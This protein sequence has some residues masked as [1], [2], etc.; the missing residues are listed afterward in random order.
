MLVAAGCS[1]DV[2]RPAVVKHYYL[3]EVPAETAE[4]PPQF[5]VPIKVSGFEVAPPF[6]D[7]AIVYRMDEQRYE[8]DFYNEFFVAP[9]AMVT[10]RISDWLAARRIFSAALP[11]S[12]TVDA[13]YAIEGLVKSLYVDLRLENQPKAVFALQVFVTRIGNPERRIVLERTYSHE[14][15]LA[16]RNPETLTNG[17]S[18]ALQLCLADLERDL[19]ALDIKP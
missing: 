10:S 2:S 4:T 7:R 5:T 1:L 3:L 8:S 18:Q 14:F 19:R 9:R 6:A 12:S 17:L 11:P 15:A 13:P 16:D